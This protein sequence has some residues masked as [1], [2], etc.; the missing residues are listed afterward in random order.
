LKFSVAD[1]LRYYEERPLTYK[2]AYYIAI[3]NKSPLTEH[4]IEAIRLKLARLTHKRPGLVW[5]M[6]T[7]TTESTGK[8]EKAVVHTGRRG[9]PMKVIKGEKIPFHAHIGIY[10]TDNLSPYSDAVEVARLINKRKGK[11]A[12]ERA[13]SNGG[14][15]YMKYA[16][17]QADHFYTSGNFDFDYILSPY[18]S[19]PLEE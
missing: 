19:E 8:V 10:S 2:T 14:L 12:S 11:V 5:F 15:C 9:R 17:R 3:S 13:M 18:Y 1:A 7:S 16:N 6:A 4:D